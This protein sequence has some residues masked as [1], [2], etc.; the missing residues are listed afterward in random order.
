MGIFDKVKKHHN[1]KKYGIKG[2]DVNPN[3]VNSMIDTYNNLIQHYD[4]TTGK[5]VSD[6]V[7]YDKNNRP[8]PMQ[9]LPIFGVLGEDYSTIVR[10]VA[11]P[12][13]G[14]WVTCN[15]AGQISYR[16]LLSDKTGAAKFYAITPEKKFEQG[17]EQTICSYSDLITGEKGSFNQSEIISDGKRRKMYSIG[18]SSSTE[19]EKEGQFE[20]DLKENL[21]YALT[22]PEFLIKTQE[23]LSDF[24]ASQKESKIAAQKES[25]DD[26]N[27][28]KA[29]GEE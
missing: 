23:E 27:N 1:L 25:K 22:L 29:M 26:F 14:C 24:I 21:E 17:K 13:M 4:S 12:G 15:G 7:Y 19:G 11:V 9:S 6:A 3:G 28:D 16:V 10:S 18:L 8:I 20:Q 2:I 5:P